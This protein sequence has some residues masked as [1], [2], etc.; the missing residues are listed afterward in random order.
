MDK[1]YAKLKIELLKLKLDVMELKQDK[2]YRDN[3]TR[4]VNRDPELMFKMQIEEEQKIRDEIEELEK[5]VNKS[6]PFSVASMMNDIE[7]F[8]KISEREND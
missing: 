4:L 3:I 2:D 6:C 7:Q 1:E 5:E 8:R